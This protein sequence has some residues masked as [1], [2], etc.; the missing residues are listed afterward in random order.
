MPNAST[1]APV[2][3]DATIRRRFTMPHIYVILMGLIV[4]ACVLTHL[5]PAGLYDRVPGPGGRST[6]DPASFH[7]IDATP[8]GLRDVVMAVPQGLVSVS[9]VIFFVF[10]IGGVFAVLRRTGIVEIGVSRLSHRFARNS[11]MLMPLLMFLFGAVASVIGTPELSMVYV[12]ILLPLFLALGYDSLTAAAVALCS[13]CAGYAAG[14]LNPFN[15]GLA[16]RLSDLPLYSGWSL[17][18]AILIA[19]LVSCIAYVMWYARRIRDNPE[20]GLL[21]D[22]PAEREKRRQY[23]EIGAGPMLS[24][25]RRQVW[26]A[27]I[28]VA[29]FG[30]L[31]YGVTTQGWYMKELTGLFLAMGIAVGLVAG[32][33]GNEI[34]DGFSEGFRDV[35]VG[36]LVAGIARGVGVVLESGHILDTIVHGLSQIV[37]ELPSMLTAIGMLLSQMGINFVVPSGSAQ[38]LLTMP[39]MGPLGDIVGVTRQTTVLA[40]QMG[41]GYSNIVYPTAGYFIATLSVAN[42]PWSRWIRFFAPLFGIWFSIVVSFLIYAQLTQWHG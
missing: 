26:A 21:Y 5:I 16:Q 3:A 23:Q 40:Y 19:L 25:T 31:I 33:D 27:M 39:I 28:A 8:A 24:A 34:S 7:F 1:S 18:V 15:T 6:V 9:E 12:P 41:D 30:V 37:G 2:S 13:T 22:N 29:F 20:K 36:A 17:R 42:V 35:L 4:L 38:A 32:L 10:M 14:V 11:L